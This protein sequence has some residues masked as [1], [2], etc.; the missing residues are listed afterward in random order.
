MNL[1]HLY[2]IKRLKESI[3]ASVWH[4]HR[5]NELSHN[6]DGVEVFEPGIVHLR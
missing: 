6:T 1:Q 5:V 4:L 3:I 2:T